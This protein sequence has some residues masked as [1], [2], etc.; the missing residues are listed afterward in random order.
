[1]NSRLLRISDHL[2]GM[3]WEFVLNAPKVYPNQNY[4]SCF[5]SSDGQDIEL[6]VIYSADSLCISTHFLCEMPP[7]ITDYQ[8]S[9]ANSLSQLFTELPTTDQQQ[10]H[11][12]DQQGQRVWPQHR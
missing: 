7:P 3:G 12:K 4:G 9:I 2:K 8:S 11:R 5:A 1:M 10:H 6:S